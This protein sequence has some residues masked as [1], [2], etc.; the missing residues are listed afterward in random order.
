M[1]IKTNEQI[2][3]EAKAYLTKTSNHLYTTKGG[4]I[5]KVITFERDDK[6]YYITLTIGNGRVMLNV[7]NLE[8]N[9]T[10]YIQNYGN[11]ALNVLKDSIY[12][13]YQ[14]TKSLPYFKKMRE[15]S[16]EI[17][18]K[19]SLDNKANAELIEDIKSRLTEFELK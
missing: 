19:I 7:K 15:L 2:V 9:M 3:K 5:Y 6:F 18:S 1:T 16:K 14:E 8:E 17:L 10:H 12:P 13:R 4:F 11:N